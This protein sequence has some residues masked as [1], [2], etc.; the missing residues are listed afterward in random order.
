MIINLE[1]RINLETS[2]LTWKRHYKQENIAM[3]LVT[4]FLLRKHN[5]QK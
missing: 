3:N 2:L 4:L 1:T 5:F